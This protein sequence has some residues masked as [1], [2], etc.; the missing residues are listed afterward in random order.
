MNR[1]IIVLLLM[2]TMVCIFA[3]SCAEKTQTE[4]SFLAEQEELQGSE[5]EKSEA[6]LKS[7]ERNE[8]LEQG[9]PSES[10][11]SKQENDALLDET[12]NTLYELEETINSLEDVTDSDLQIPE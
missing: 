9:T 7:T 5:E 4:D 8:D 10:K 1:K 6:L 2:I 3:T 12:L 11:L